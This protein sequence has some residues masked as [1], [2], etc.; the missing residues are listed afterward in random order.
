MMLEN[1]CKSVVN[2]ARV[3]GEFAFSE[4]DMLTR[5]HIRYKNNDRDIVTHVDQACE[6]R[7][8][9]GLQKVLP[10][11]TFITEEKTI[12]NLQGEM[13]WIIDPLDGTTNFV[14]HIPFFSV[15]I[16]LMMHGRIVLGVVF[17]PCLD[18]CFHSHEGGEVFLNDQRIEVS[19]TRNL[20]E[21][22]I[23]TGFP[24]DEMKNAD[25]YME[26]LKVFTSHAHGVRRFG[27]AAIDL[28][29]V[30]C[31]RF[32][33]FYEAGLNPWDVAAGAFLVK[34]AGGLVTDFSGGD[35]FL[36]GN[37]IIASNKAL[38]PRFFDLT[39][40]YLVSGSLNAVPKDKY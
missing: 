26:L 22:M 37:E 12:D 30:A 17:N 10:E 18:E 39:N 36:F 28:A 15:S 23:A 31:G 25:Q 32:D 16:A 2:V 20:A 33:G 9:S 8:V 6:R 1:I 21:A 24:Y 34:Q 4:L 13:T 29:W 19:N 35:D 7:I 38:F 40:S 11:A 3:A 27:S 5:E 14:H